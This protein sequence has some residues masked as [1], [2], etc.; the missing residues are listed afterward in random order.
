MN[1]AKR[2]AA[3]REL[4]AQRIVMLDGAMGTMIQRHELV[5]KD[6]RGNRLADHPSPLAGNHDLLCLTRPDVIGEIHRLYLD[7]GSDLI[8]TNTFNA[9]AISQADYGTEHLVSEINREAARIARAAADEAT[10]ADPS[11]PRFVAGAMG[12][13]NRT[14]SLSPD[15]ENPSFRAVTFEELAAAYREQAIGLLDGGVDILLVETVFDTLNCKAAIHA[16]LTLA[17]ERGEPIPMAI[18]GT[19]TDKSGRTLSGQTVEAFWA[20][21]AHARPVFVGLNCALGARDLLPHTDDLS[22]IADTAISCYP[23]AGLPNEFGEYE[24]T[25]ESMAEVLSEFADRDLLNLVG[26]CCGTTPDHIRAIAAAVESSP[27]R[28]FADP[29]PWPTFAGL[30]PLVVHPDLLFVNIGERTNVTGSREFARLIEQGRYDDAVE[31]ARLQ[32]ANGAQMLD[33]NMDEGLLDSEA[34]MTRFLNLIAAEPDIARVPVVIDSSRWEVIEAGLRCVQ[35]KPI[36]NSI[37]LKDG[38]EEFLRRA[39]SARRFGAA[40]IVMAFDE[41]GQ[42]ETSD[43]KFEICARAYKLLTDVAG[44]APSDIIFDANVFAVG[45]GIREHAEYGTAFMEAVRR[46]KQELPGVA[47]SG[48]ISNASF[49]FRGNEAVREA[50]HAVFLYH[51]IAAG[52]DMGIVNSGRLPIYDDIDP[53]LR[54]AAEDVLLNRGDTAEATERLTAMAGRARAMTSMV[55]DDSAWREWTVEKRLEHALVEGILD[56]IEQDVEEAR[57][58]ANLALEVVEGPLMDGMSRVGDLFGSGRMFLPQVVKS[59]RV[60]KRAVAQ[61]IPYM[62]LESPVGEGDT[63]GRGRILM[64]TVKGDVHDIGKNIVG[65]VLACN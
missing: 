20:S 14:A 1:R 28:A 64:A 58:G 17:E 33:V 24:E 36:V 4:I 48:G 46:I 30:E 42:A 55:R 25:P 39:R 59:A 8:G 44:F 23:N 62:E 54:E 57:L 6:Y 21:I 16:I 37:S 10:A 31:V 18:S 32:V 52:L 12:P 2:A 49:A 53:E 27:P 43:R 50:M 5:E 35:G 7:A 11:R 41:Q 40:V 61:L 51:A 15:V 45:T 26:G 13:T 9:Q 34:A 29:S 47:T 65:V 63:K 19:I 38:E 60:M 22:R 56:H 3:L